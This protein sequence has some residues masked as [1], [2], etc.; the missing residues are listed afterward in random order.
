ML[1]VTFKNMNPSN[2]IKEYAETK[3][4]RIERHFTKPF[5]SQMTLTM[6]RFNHVANVHIQTK[7]KLFQFSE[8]TK[9]MYASIDK[10]MDKVERTLVKYKEK[11][12]N[13]K[14]EKEPVVEVE[15]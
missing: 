6:E 9:D 1:Q 14:V 8:K 12:K 7:G 5:V 11:I 10:V 4:K 3:L 15:I 2:P 13:H